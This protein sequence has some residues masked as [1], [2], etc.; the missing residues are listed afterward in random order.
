MQEIKRTIVSAI[1]ISQDK[2]ILLGKVRRGGVYPD[3]WHIPGGGV[4]EGESKQQALIREIKEELGLDI[5]S[6][7]KKLISDDQTGTAQKTSRDGQ[8]Q[9][10]VHMQFNVYQVELPMKATSV[11]LSLDDDLREIRWVGKSRLKN[12]KLNPPSEKLFSRLGWV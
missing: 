8:R 4:D 2:K 1:L 12:V 10:L 6:Y 9:Y 5:S 11:K 3:S 7:Q